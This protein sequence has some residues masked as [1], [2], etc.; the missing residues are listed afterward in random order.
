MQLSLGTNKANIK[1]D[2]LWSKDLILSQVGQEEIFEKYLNRPVTYRGKFRNPLRR[3]ENPTCTFT[4]K[5]GKLLF[6][7]WAEEKAK[8]CFNI[9]QQIHNVDFY[10]ALEIIAR[11]FNL[12][13]KT[14]REGETYQPSVSDYRREKNNEKSIIQVKVQPWTTDNKEY[15]KSYGITSKIAKYYRV[16]CPKYVWLNG[17]PLYV[18]SDD[19]PALAYYFGTDE[20]G[21]EKWKIYFYTSRDNWRFIGNTNRINGWVQIPE[22]GPLLVITKSMKDVMCLARFGIPAISMQGETQIPYDYIID[23]LKSR[24]NTIYTLLDFDRTGVH[25]AWTIRKLY[26]IPAIFFDN[27]FEAKD[28][29]DYVRDNGLI[30]TK[31]LVL[32]TLDDLGIDHSTFKIHEIEFP[33]TGSSR[34]S[35]QSGTVEEAETK[36]LQVHKEQEK[37]EAKSS[38]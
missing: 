33:D 32:K 19:K 13:N 24:F 16:Y 14:P 7:D 21:R 9:V 29:S 20:Q 26:D 10:T 30:A 6:R 36:V 15:L 3:D 11:D 34:V 2:I 37:V 35:Y 12:T 22:S 28:F 5:G 38:T 25:A 27:R 4:W 1:E 18:Y 23:E 17:N 31:E 8:D